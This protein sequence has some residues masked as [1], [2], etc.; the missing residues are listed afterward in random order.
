MK[1]NRNLFQVIDAVSSS[2]IWLVLFTIM[3]QVIFRYVIH[4]PLIWTEELSRYMLIWLVFSGAI[5]LA[6]DGEHVRVDF[7]VNFM[8]VWLQTFLSLVVNLVIGFSLIAL[9]IGSWGPLQD[10]TYLKS[11]A[12]Q[13]PLIFVFIIVPVSS[14]FMLIHYIK[15]FFQD[16]K[17]LYGFCRKGEVK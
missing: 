6:K 13:M 11:P 4:K 9:L 2:L 10:F 15:S 14:F 3:L 1:K 16:L 17:T 5:L 7:F 8:P 12:M